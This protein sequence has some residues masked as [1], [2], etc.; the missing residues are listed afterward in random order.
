MQDIA[1]DLDNIALII[2]L[3]LRNLERPS[4]SQH[5][6]TD[7]VLID[8]SNEILHPLVY[9][10]HSDVLS[11]DCNG[12]Y[13]EA[14]LRLE[15]NSF[16][17]LGEVL[18]IDKTKKLITLTNNVFVSYKH[19]IIASGL[20]QA[21]LGSQYDDDLSDGFN[22][23]FE[24]LRVRRNITQ[25]LCFPELSHLGFYPKKKNRHKQLKKVRDVPIKSIQRILRPLMTS[26]AEKSLDMTLGG[27][28]KRLYQVQL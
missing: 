23:L 10:L 17:M 16:A 26:K 9:Q 24:A 22:A 25:A 12:I 20:R 4:T 15:E 5:L 21:V 18:F 28:D 14:L 2:G 3:N 6:F 7:V 27:A 8:K 19:L 11:E 13:Q 1:M